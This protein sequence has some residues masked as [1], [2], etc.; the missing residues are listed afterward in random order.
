MENYNG[1]PY[2]CEYCFNLDKNPYIKNYG[3]HL[4]TKKHNEIVK[5][6]RKNITKH[7]NKTLDCKIEGDLTFGLNSDIIFYI[8]LLEDEIK[9]CNKMR[10]E[11]GRAG[12]IGKMKI[13][14][15][16]KIWCLMENSNQV[17]HNKIDNTVN[18]YKD[19]DKIKQN[20]LGNI[21]DGLYNEFH[22]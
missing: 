20:I 12:I 5:K 18:I 10:D 21:I 14:I 8:G 16:Q 22:K 6:I 17:Y 2:A 15:L 9:R 19:Y 11:N 13:E 3:K 7:Y 1:I 4:L